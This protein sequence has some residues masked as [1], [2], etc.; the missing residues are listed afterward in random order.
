MEK[1]LALLS[2][3]GIPILRHANKLKLPVYVVNVSEEGAREIN[4]YYDE[5]LTSNYNKIVRTKSN[6]ISISKINF[7]PPMWDVRYS[8]ACL[9]ITVIGASR[10]LRI[11]FRQ[12]TALDADKTGEERQIYGRQAFNAFKKELLKDGIDL[13]DYAIDNGADVKKTIP[14]YLIR[15]AD[16]FVCGKERTWQ[17]CH[18][19]DFHN[20]FP[21]G[22]VN[23]HPEFGKTIARLY[24]SRKTNPINK[25]IL[26][27]SIGFFQ[28][29]D[30]CQAKWAHLSKDAIADNNDR[31]LELSQRITD[32][33]RR[34]LLWN[35]DG[36]WYQGEIYHGEGEGKNLGEWENDHI[37]C[38]FRAKSRGA[39][40]FIEDGKYYP[41]LR[42]H[43]KLDKAKP[44]DTWEWGDIFNL[45]AEV[46]N[47][48]WIEGIGL[49]D[50][51][52]NK[53]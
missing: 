40:E 19:I 20:S 14:K 31:V 8:R 21:A 6:G 22:L 3:K 49:V 28:S 24:E 39:Y 43:T 47:F 46:I 44:R 53:I 27:Y 30:G 11:Q 33:G 50:E 16:K 17:G 5:L 37:N 41:V 23:T 10:M 9:E 38:Q 2:A 12:N 35:T 29:L 32:A 36:I 7:R 34:V 52:N 45:D 4:E 48:Y 51:Y 15:E 26:N 13:D 42:G 18:H 25:A 1:V